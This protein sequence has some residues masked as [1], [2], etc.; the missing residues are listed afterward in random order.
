MTHWFNALGSQA[1]GP[2]LESRWEHSSF[3]LKSPDFVPVAPRVAF[4]EMGQ[5]RIEN[6]LKN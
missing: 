6:K 1:K 2:G 5:A 4:S 3:P